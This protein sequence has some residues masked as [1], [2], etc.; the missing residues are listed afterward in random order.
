MLGH[1]LLHWHLLGR[2][3]PA[4]LKFVNSPSAQ[5]AQILVA[6]PV[7]RFFLKSCRLAVTALRCD[8]LRGGSCAGIFLVGS[9]CI[10]WAR[11]LTAALASFGALASCGAKICELAFGSN[12]TNFGRA[13]GHSLLPPKAACLQSLLFAV[14]S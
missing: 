12:S 2:L 5:T 8:E 10:M 7:T 13:F 6:P 4:A 1:C 14:T 11:A 9:F 3:L